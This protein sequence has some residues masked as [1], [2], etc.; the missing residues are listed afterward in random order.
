L[1]GGGGKK[2]KCGQG[3]RRSKGGLGG[4]KK[5]YRGPKEKSKLIDLNQGIGKE[6]HRFG[7]GRGT[8][9]KEGEGREQLMSHVSGG[10]LM[11]FRSDGLLNSQKRGGGKK[12]T[13]SHR[14]RF[15]EK[16]VEGGTGGEK[17]G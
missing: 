9:K 11:N 5:G 16:C 4:P 2:K 17:S 7:V 12:T 1:G 13:H 14:T 15:L 8:K 6:G 3:L 10:S